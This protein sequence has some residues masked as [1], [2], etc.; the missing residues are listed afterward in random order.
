MK[1]FLRLRIY[2]WL[3]CAIIATGL[4]FHIFSG[5]VLEDSF[6]TNILYVALFMLV[7]MA[8]M[9]FLTYSRITIIIGVIAGVAILLLAM[10]YTRTHLSFG[11]EASETANSLFIAL[12][13]TA[14]TAVLVYL[15]CRTRAGTI[16]LF[17]AGSIVIAGSVFLQFPVHRWSFLLFTFA[18]VVMYL[19]RNYTI[20]LSDAQTGHFRMPKF[21]VQ[22]VVVCLVAFVLS[23]T[24]YV[25]IVRPLQ[26]PTRELKLIEELKQMSI[27]KR[28]GLYSVVELLDPSLVSSSDPS[29]T[30]SGQEDEES[31]PGDN[32]AG[33]NDGGQ[34]QSQK[35][36]EQKLEETQNVYYLI[37][38]WYI[39]WF[40]II[41]A[42]VIA[43]VFLTRWVLKRNWKRQVDALPPDLRVINYYRYFL[44]RL[45]RLGYKKPIN[46]T[47]YEYAEDMDHTLETFTA[48]EASFAKLTDIYVKT[49]YGRDQVPADES[50]LF[51]QFFTRFHKALRKEVGIWKYMLNFFRI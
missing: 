19:Y 33:D 8:V 48:G 18:T 36:P 35:A 41:L 15:A 50:G 37:H 11:D 45:S 16:V 6:S 12:F 42:A 46:H 21:M 2:D 38:F 26:P 27:V 25:G 13:A 7:A 51:Q 24:A 39:P 34:D 1:D 3:L 43:A 28:M 40:W 5:F 23:G 4:V 44:T 9:V 20:T 17:L 49:L 22:T 10:V 31:A 32:G 47:L 29:G 14:L 30:E